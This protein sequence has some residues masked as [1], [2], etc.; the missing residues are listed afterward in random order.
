MSDL[1]KRRVSRRGIMKGAAAGIAAAALTACAPKVVEVT[2]VVEK[3]VE[4]EV[5]KVVEKI[6]EKEPGEKVVRCI[7]EL[8]CWQKLG[9]A[10]ATDQYNINNR[11]KLRIEADPSPSGWQTKVIQ[12]VKDDELLW[13]GMIRSSDQ[14]DIPTFRRM[15]IIQP[16]DELINGSEVPWAR[17]YFDEVLPRIRD[18]YTFEGKLWGIPW[19][20][21]IWAR[22]YQKPYWDELGE[23]PAETI[24]DFERQLLELKKL[25]P[26]KVPFGSAHWEGECDTHTYMQMFTDEDFYL[27]E[28]GYSMPDVH[29]DA[30][31]QYLTLMKKWYDLGIFTDDTWGSK[32]WRD[33]WLA[34]KVCCV[35]TN[36]AWAMSQAQKVWGTANIVPTVQPVLKKGNQSKTFTFTNGAVCFKGAPQ[37]QEYVDWLLWMLD[38][39]IEKVENYSFHKW[40]LN[41]MHLPVYE[42]VYTNIIPT[43][44]DWAWMG[45]L[46]PMVRASRLT[47]SDGLCW[48]TGPIEAVWEEKFVHGK[49][50]LEEAINGMDEE[51][52]AA[53]EK[54]FTELG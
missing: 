20:A 43:N 51:R 34:G 25:L 33:S 41:Y 53:V 46:F 2:R 37:A 49:V 26:D 8:W 45:K 18:G 6:V 16:V 44:P 9:M 52:R 47:P 21:E 28:E 5:T 11:G 38:P 15:G 40:D 14:G 7:T 32:V 42:S 24:D 17:S 23:E 39:T 19:D 13:N 35:I 22:V 31:K 54:H 4:K 12:M 36:A 50:T 27:H 3:E 48:T 10:T 1:L 30:Y 29:H